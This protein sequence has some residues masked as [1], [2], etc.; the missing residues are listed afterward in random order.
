MVHATRVVGVNTKMPLSGD[1]IEEPDELLLLRYLL[2]ETN[3]TETVAVEA[4]V[5]KSPENNEMLS[6]IARLYHAQQTQRRVVARDAHQAFDRLHLRLRRKARIHVLKRIAVAASLLIGL[7]GISS[8]L[9]QRQPA[10]TWITVYAKNNLRNAFD[11]PDGTTV[12]LNSSSSL[13]YPAEFIGAQRPV[14][15]VGE[16]YFKVA[17]NAQQPFV[18]RT[19][20]DRLAVKVLGTEF[21]VSAY[22]NDETIQTTL[23]SGSIELEIPESNLKKVLK[24][25][26]K[27][28]FT[29]HNNELS[30]MPTDVSQ[31]TDWMYNKLVFRETSMGD[32][33]KRLAR[34]YEVQFEI[35]DDIIYGY[36]FT[37][38]FENKQLHQVLEYMKVSS[39]ID[40]RI[41]HVN[42]ADQR[43]TLVELRARR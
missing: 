6:R 35:K 13:S 1:H 5:N 12:H 38:A 8:L 11:L 39:K 43:G 37:G 9:W 33:L 21:T 30:V 27:A 42:G 18:V 24:P 40:Y 29:L 28:T 17:H 25:N 20:G 19:A 15:L 16:A 2:E 22:A 4:W 31:A 41:R 3:P 34:F 26:Q 10:P 32:V 7:F 23:I 36:T 14:K